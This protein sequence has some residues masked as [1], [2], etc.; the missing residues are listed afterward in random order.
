MDVVKAVETYITRMVSTPPSM[1]VLLLDN[2]TVGVG[3]ILPSYLSLIP[4]DCVPL[5]THSLPFSYAVHS[6]FAS[7]I[8]YG[9][10]RQQEA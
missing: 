4:M 1:K 9:Q 5:D 8:P 3:L 6:S 7:G 10:D 2:H